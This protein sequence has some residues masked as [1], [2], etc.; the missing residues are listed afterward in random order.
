MPRVDTGRVALVVT[1]PPYPMIEMWDACFSAQDPAIA[2][3]L[4]KK[5]GLGAFERMHR[6]LDRV[7][8]EV[9]RVLMPGG[10]VCINIGDATRTLA[11]NFILYPNHARILSALLPLGL[12]PLPQILWRKQ[13]NAPNKFMGSGM[14]PPGAYVT[15]EHEHILIARKGEKRTFDTSSEKQLRRESAYFW[16]ERNLWFSDVWMELKGARQDLGENGARARSAAFPF[17]LPY[18]LIQ[19]FSVKGDV[20]LDPFLGTGTTLAAAMAAGRDSIGIEMEKEFLPLVRRRVE[21]LVPFS[22]TRIRERL[23]AHEAFIQA[24]Y[25]DKGG[26]RHQ[27]AHYGFPVITNQERFLQLQDPTEVRHLSATEFEVSYESGPQGE[28]CRKWP[29]YFDGADKRAKPPGRPKKTTYPKPVQRK[30]L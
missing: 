28:F 20:V 15:L 4:K 24:R 11:D 13:T 23:A 27:N 29:G 7:W 2:T 8:K 17:E 1:S 14:L 16:E 5:D 26:F 6:I 19:M 22:R 25:Q 21:T 10:I 12:T 9:A 18:R 3:A 30:I